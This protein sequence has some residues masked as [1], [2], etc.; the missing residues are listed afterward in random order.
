[1]NGINAEKIFS[2]N[3]G[4]TYDDIILLPGFIKHAVNE[5]SL[6]TKL[7][8]N[9][10]LHTP[11]ISSP[12]DTVTESNM[13]I[14]IAL[15]GGLG[16]I[17]CNNSIDTQVKQVKQVKKYNN[18][19]ITDPIVLSEKHTVENVLD[20]QKKY[21]F[22]GF[23][24]TENG[25]IG[26][27]L[28]GFISQ[29]DY[30][31]VD[32]KETF[33]KELMTTKLVVGKKTKDFSLKKAYDI[34]REKKVNRLPIINEKGELVSLI[35]RKDQK[36]GRD[37]PNATKDP[38]TSQLIV[39]ASVTTHL[40]DRERID[41]LVEDAKVDILVID[42]SQGNSLYQIET[43]QYIKQKY[44]H[45]DV[46]GGNIVT[47][48]QAKNLIDAGVNAIRV[49][50]GIG[51]ICTT[52]NVCGVGRPQASAIYDVAKYC[53]ERDISVIADGGISNSGHIVKALNLGA[54]CI[55]LGS[56]LAGTDESAGDTFYQDGIKLKRYRGMGSV[57]AMKQNSSRRYGVQSNMYVAQGVN[58][59][60][61]C[62]GSIHNF[63]PY[64]MQGVKHGFQNIGIENMIESH[65]RLYNGE[66]KFEIRSLASQVEGNIHNLFEHK[67]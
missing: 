55:M 5:I 51:S 30:D 40:K 41:Q 50:M 47:S 48:N 54:S 37:F 56:L 21:G 28:V 23:P 26:S 58:G 66:T 52:Q 64:L 15:Q 22:S 29:R 65:K 49:G 25:K 39:G 10:T 33:V 11:I 31:F 35:S 61:S 16:I 42:S 19:F 12:M 8:N 36:K 3:F 24:V 59:S 44:P 60:V 9:I 62:K 46:I 6:S 27:K 34:L 38:V 7:T 17:H 1:M 32:K 43:I 53:N 57:E 20:I 4:Y 18:G 2:A 13:A 63:V 67:D 14:N 45:I